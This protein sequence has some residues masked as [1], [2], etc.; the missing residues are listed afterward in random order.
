MHKSLHTFIEILEVAY[1][2]AAGM[3]GTTIKMQYMC[4]A[5]RYDILKNI[6]VMEYINIKYQR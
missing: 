6:K 1:H 5:V 4:M 2:I 3:I